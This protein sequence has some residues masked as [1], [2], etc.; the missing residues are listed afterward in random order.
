M[1]SND[2]NQTQ[3]QLMQQYRAAMQ[4]A[5]TNS[6]VEGFNQALDGMLQLKADALREAYESQIQQ[7]REEYNAQVLTT[8]G[9][10]QLT[11]QEREYY[12]K[13]AEAAGGENPRQ[14]VANL[15]VVT[16][17]SIVD[18]VFDDL[19]TNH[20]LLKHLN[21]TAAAG[22]VEIIINTNG[23]QSA[24]WGALSDAVV[25]EA[26][27]G[28][29]QVSANLLKLSAFLPV[30][31]AM[32][33]LGPEWLDRFV[34]ET[35][36]EC[37]A[38]G[39]EA[40]Y[41]AG[42]GKNQPIGMIKQFGE[43]VSVVDGVYPDKEAI[44]ITDLSTETVGGLLG[45]LAVSSEGA[46]RAVR[47]LIFIT[48]PVDYYTKVMPAT[49]LMA[50]DGSYRN[51]VMPYPMDVIQSPS[52]PAN[53]AVLGMG[54]R[55]VALLGSPKDGKIEYSDHYRFLEDERM[56]LIK[57]YSNGFAMDPNDFLLLDISQLKPLMLAL[58]MVA[59]E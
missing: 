27:A 45:K 29:K 3:A 58:Q 28:F 10:N 32:L 6:D 22:L 24:I 2:L 38:N 35:L 20:P 26:A 56:Y 1:R 54:K 53:K 15:P 43:G 25:K 47:D 17:R 44:A 49:T 12:Q 30:C 23:Y 7:V 34:R 4:T 19:R 31:K 48:S 57:A 14:A 11:S 59:E 40:G 46:N 42:N 50:P 41:I 13:F 51:D 55:Y 5:F 33:E 21:F 16:P 9:V 52:V 36:Y 8:R 18:R 39:L 37:L